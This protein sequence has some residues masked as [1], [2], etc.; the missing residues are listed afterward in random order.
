MSEIRLRWTLSE[1]T[2]IAS[3]AETL[4]GVCSN[5]AAQLAGALATADP[6]DTA[7]IAGI[8]GEIRAYREVVKWFVDAKRILANP[9]LAADAPQEPEPEDMGPPTPMGYMGSLV[10]PDE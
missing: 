3:D 9:K 7:R 1:A 5:Y 2:R 6:R 4:P 10:G 8:Q